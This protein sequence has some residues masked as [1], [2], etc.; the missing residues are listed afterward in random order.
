M[1]TGYTADIHDGKPVTFEAFAMQ[2]ARAFGA[3]IMMRDSATDAP[4]PE[5]F[6]PSTWNDERLAEAL[7]DTTQLVAMTKEQIEAAATE[8]NRLAEES[9]QKAATKSREMHARYTD[10]LKQVLLWKPPTPDHEKLRSFMENQLRQ[11]IHADCSTSEKPTP[12][13]PAEWHDEQVKHFDWLINYHRDEA[14]K[15]KERVASRNKW[16]SD[17]RASLKAC[18]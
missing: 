2:C 7:A 12:L 5:A 4:I 18:K 15:E 10:M 14:A 13:T 3:L 17:L 6:E 11:S 9:W 8:A 16:L 1:P